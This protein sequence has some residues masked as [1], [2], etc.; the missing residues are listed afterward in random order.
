MCILTFLKPGHTPDLDALQGGALANP[1]GHGYA[2]HTGDTLLVGHG[3]DAEKM[4]AEF[5]DVRAKHPQGPALFHSRYATHGPRDTSNCHPFFVGGDRRTVLAHNGILPDS[6]HPATGDTR[7]DTRVAAEEFL[8]ARP[9]GSLDTWDG[10]DRFEQWLGPNKIVLLTTD[11]A[12]KHPAYIFNEHLGH[13]VDGAWYSNDS[14][15]LTEWAS[16][17]CDYA[18]FCEFCGD[19]DDDRPGPHCGYCGFCADCANPFPDCICPEFDGQQ[20]YADL[21]D[22]QTT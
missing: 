22:F 17:E 19:Y 1:H 11:P 13:W 2:V 6:V 3:M 18:G 21:Y 5:A 20:R 10:R 14:Y 8:P 16:A 9:F 4:I 12:Y 7:S 15:L